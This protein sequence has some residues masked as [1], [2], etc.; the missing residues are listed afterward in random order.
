M[1]LINHNI[2]VYLDAARRANAAAFGGAGEI[3]ADLSAVLDVIGEAFAS[4]D[5]QR[6]LGKNQ[7]LLDRVA[8]P[9]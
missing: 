2:W 3:P 5:W 6:V 1:M 8:G 7:Q 4:S 9:A